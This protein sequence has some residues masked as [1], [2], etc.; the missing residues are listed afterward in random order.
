MRRLSCFR[1]FDE[2]L[3]EVIVAFPD[4][5]PNGDGYVIDAIPHPLDYKIVGEV[6]YQKEAN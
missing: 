5:D 1:Y 2:Y 3:L 6:I 4:S